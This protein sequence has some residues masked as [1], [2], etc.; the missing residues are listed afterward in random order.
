[1]AATR[2][3]AFRAQSEQFMG[4]SIVQHVNGTLHGIHRCLQFSATDLLTGRQASQ[5]MLCHAGELIYK[6]Q[7]LWPGPVIRQDVPY[8]DCCHDSPSANNRMSAI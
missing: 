1:M 4:T 2:Q 5:Q 8:N 6:Y 3:A 7:A